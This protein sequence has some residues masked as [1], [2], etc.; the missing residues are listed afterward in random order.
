MINLYLDNSQKQ[1]FYSEKGEEMTPYHR[2]IMT[3]DFAEILDEIANG[4]IPSGTGQ[5]FTVEPIVE[6]ETGSSNPK[7]NPWADLQNY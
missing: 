1:P 7:S 2:Y 3:K 5:P 4:I 6:F